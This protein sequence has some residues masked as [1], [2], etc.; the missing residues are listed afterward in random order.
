MTFPRAEDFGVG[1]IYRLLAILARPARHVEA[2]IGFAYLCAAFG[3]ALS[4]AIG[5]DEQGSV[6]SIAGLVLMS[7]SFFALFYGS[8]VILDAAQAAGD[9]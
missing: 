5:F 1:V 4:L 3:L 9:R 8:L 2:I 6:L 7:I